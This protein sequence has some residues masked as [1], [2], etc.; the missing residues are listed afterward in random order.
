MKQDK[1]KEIELQNYIGDL[2]SHIEQY[3]ISTA[4]MVEI[5]PEEADYILDEF[6]QIKYKGDEYF[7]TLEKSIIAK[8]KP[9][10]EGK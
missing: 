2:K 7:C 6:F 3:R 10:A 8:L 4:N 5:T 1:K 9:I